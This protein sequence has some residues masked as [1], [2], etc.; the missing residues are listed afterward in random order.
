MFHMVVIIRAST[1]ETSWGRATAVNC[2]QAAASVTAEACTPTNCRQFS[3]SVAALFR[4]ANWMMGSTESMVNF[5]E[6]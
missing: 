1:S 6:S 2:S 3:S 4:S 5:A